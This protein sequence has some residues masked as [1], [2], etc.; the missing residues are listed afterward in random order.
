MQ[1]FDPDDLRR[2]V[3]AVVVA[4]GSDPREARLVAAQLV[5][6]NLAGHDSHGV[7]MLPTYVEAVVAGRLHVNQSPRPVR[8]NG[9]VLVLDGQRGYGAVM[10]QAVV[11]AATVRARDHGVT[12]VGLRNS[13]H[14]GRI[15]HW[16][17]QLAAAGLVAIHMVNVAGHDPIVAPYGGAEARFAT[18]PVC[19]AV[20]GG[21]D[22][23]LTMVDMATSIIAG[24]KARVAL[25]EGKPVPEGT[26][27]D[28]DGR[29]TTDPSGMFTEPRRGALVAFGEH[30]GS[31]LAVM[32]EL[33]ASALIGGPTVHPDHPRD[34]SILNSMLTIAIDPAA[35]GRV[36]EFRHEAEAYLD[37]VRSCRPRDG[38]DEVLVPNEPEHRARR[39]RAKAVP[40]A[41]ATVE[42]LVAA[43]TLV[44][45]GA[46]GETLVASAR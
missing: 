27:L 33:L 13:F 18:N 34:E 17:E 38:F 41:A 42:E 30:K 1:L 11:D 5:E 4:T 6:A 36:E 43:A 15:G 7:G 2:F 10:G 37:Y 35:V 8:D 25:A 31:A 12:F 29:V 16:G 23:P 14:L 44:D 21:V 22:G 39:R 40:V 24:G 20:P 45:A 32:C 28:A 9:S 3:D 46:V 19:I 26:L